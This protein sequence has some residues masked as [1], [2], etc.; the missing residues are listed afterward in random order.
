MLKKIET[1]FWLCILN[2]ICIFTIDPPLSL[3]VFVVLSAICMCAVNFC[4]DINKNPSGN[5]DINNIFF[6]ATDCR[7][8]PFSILMFC[9]PRLDHSIW[10]FPSYW[11]WKQLCCAAANSNFE[12]LWVCLFEFQS[13]GIYYLCLRI[14]F[15]LFNAVVKK[16]E[17]GKPCVSETRMNFV[18]N[19]PF[20]TYTMCNIFY[21]T[22]DSMRI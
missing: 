18:L 2:A 17:G 12:Y 5:Y 7:E 1:C 20:A 16:E 15:L 21:C 14:R 6:V 8:T 10:H 13:N 19:F 22:K 11:I 4:L 3:C 9:E